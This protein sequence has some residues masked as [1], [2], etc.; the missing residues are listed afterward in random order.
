MEEL[1]RVPCFPGEREKM[2]VMQK[3][4]RLVKKAPAAI[5]V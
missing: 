5:V 4:A 3:K 2:K 1:E